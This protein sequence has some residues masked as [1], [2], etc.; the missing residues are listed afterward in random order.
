MFGV[1]LFVAVA[2]GGAVLPAAMVAHAGPP[3]GTELCGVAAEREEGAMARFG[4]RK[5]QKM[6]A[7]SCGADKSKKGSFDAPIQDML[8]HLNLHGEYVSTSSCSGRIAIFWENT[9]ADAASKGNSDT[10]AM[11]LGETAAQTGSDA[12][13]SKKGGLGGQW[14]LCRHGTVTAEEVRDALARAPTSPGV[15]TFKHEPFILHV[16][17]HSL[18]AAAQLM[19][20]ARNAGFRESG[21]SI[22]KKHVMVGVRTSALKIEAPV[23]ENGHLLVDDGYLGVLVRLAND[24][25]AKNQQRT[26]KLYALL[27]RSLLLSIPPPLGNAVGAVKAIVEAAH[28]SPGQERAGSVAATDEVDARQPAGQMAVLCGASECEHVR[29]LLVK[30][31]ML[32]KSFR[33]TKQPDGRLAIPILP[34]AAAALRAGGEGAGGGGW[35]GGGDEEVGALIAGIE[36]GLMTVETVEGLQAAG[37]GGGGGKLSPHQRLVAALA[38][39]LEEHHGG[40][41]GVQGVQAAQ[42]VVEAQGNVPRRWEEYADMFVLP[43]GALKSPLWNGIDE[44]ALWSCVAQALGVRRLAVKGEVDTGRMR[45]SHVS[46]VHPPG[47]DGWVTV[48]QNGLTYSFDVGRVMFSR[49]NVNERRRMGTMSARGETAVDLYAGIGYFTIPLLAQA[50]VAHLYA[51]ELNPDSVLALRRN[52]QANGVADRCTVLPGDNADSAP[53]LRGLADR[54]NLGLLPSSEPGW[55]LA[56]AALKDATGGWLHVHENVAEADEAAWLLRLEDTLC[57]LAREC[58]KP[59]AWAC[60]VRNVEHVKTFAP[61]VWHIVADVECRPCSY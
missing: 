30:A 1:L 43:E 8:D 52:L 4:Q 45:Q 31:G 10:A 54:V 50:G 25:F 11:L 56:V 2:S 58:G 34:G 22:G 51:C 38:R 13:R 32:N 37:K 16:E 14:L 55:G 7:M 40:V 35:G 53:A 12:R 9:A 59:G 48:A 6:E 61:R 60:K 42:A 20:V 27:R 18:D 26:D 3:E 28:A 15:A 46:V 39:L 5:T 49:G 44:N 47:A 57:Q 19:E 23:L 17:C 41:K 36:K 24:K 29:G 21:I 33:N